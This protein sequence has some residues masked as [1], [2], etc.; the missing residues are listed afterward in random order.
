M[1][2]K[3]ISSVDLAAIINELQFLAEGRVTQIYQPDKKQFIFQIH[4]RGKGKQL[5]RIF[6]GMFLNLTEIKQ[7]TLRPSGL[8]LQLRKYLSNSFLRE[9]YQK[10]SERIIIFVFEG[11]D[12]NTENKEITKYYLIVELFSKGNLILT[13]KDWKIITSSTMQIWEARTVKAREQY[14]FP[15]EC[16]NWKKATL[17]QISEII[18]SSDKKNLATCLA[19]ELS[20]GG[21]YAEEIC[22]VSNIDS[23]KEISEVTDQDVKLVFSGL[24]K[25][26]ELIEKPAGYVYEDNVLPL[27]L[28]GQKPVKKLNSFNEALD[29]LNPLEKT[30][31]YEKKIKNVQGII[32]SQEE[33]IKN[34]K[35]D[36]DLNTKKGELIY[37]KYQNLLKLLDIVKEL[38][39]NKEW[40]EIGK[41]L[42]K[43]KK[44]KQV[45]LKSKKIILD[46]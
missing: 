15:P 23:K 4:A 11:K 41:E 13:D 43:E 24:K 25:V 2:K 5:L 9:V 46:L 29:T 35:N 27:E 12:P 28:V 10:D 34:L 1:V 18:K 38:R 20:L 44:I 40:T 16:F 22:K 32:G 19:T 17:K 7:S 14:E 33:A 30:S 26:L 36:I 21:L 8:C 31:P 6:P 37:E 45:N 39:K 3:N 42:K